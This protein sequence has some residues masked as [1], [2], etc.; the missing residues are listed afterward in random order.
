V[1]ALEL[2]E[3]LRMGGRGVDQLDACLGELALEGDGD[4]E[5]ASGEA[6][7]V[8]GEELARKP[9]G[10]ARGEE[11]GPG[12]L[13]AWSLA[14]DRCEEEAGVVVQAVDDPGRLASGE[15]HLRPVDL[16]EV[17]RYL[18]FEAL[19][20]LRSPRRLRGDQVVAP[21]R[22]VDRRHRRRLDPRP[23]KLGMDPARAPAPVS[24]AQ[25]DDP[26]LQRGLDP[27]R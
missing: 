2:A 15:F 21:E 23:P 16:P 12:R 9:V 24:P 25:L 10:G 4:P 19:R 14:G 22:A 17:V 7:V 5:Q 1:E 20:R 6:R 3:R 11:A 18:P 13:P 8:V 27:G 26:R